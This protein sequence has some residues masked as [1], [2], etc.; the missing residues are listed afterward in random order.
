MSFTIA[1]FISAVLTPLAGLVGRSLGLVDRPKDPTLA[2]HVR[3]V[4]VLGGPAVVAS[5]FV[6]T[7]I[8]GQSVSWWIVVAVALAL[9]VGIADD[10]RPLP[11]LVRLVGLAVAGVL[12]AMRGGE[13][14]TFGLMAAPVLVL[15]TVASA[16]A[17]NL[18]DGQNGLA[19]TLAAAAALGIAG[20]SGGRTDALALTLGGASL[21]F[22]AWNLGGLVFL[23]NGGAYAVGAML[24]AVAAHAVTERGWHGAV[25]AVL[26][27]G[28]FAFE[29]VFTIVRRL[30]T[31][32]ALTSGD[33]LHAYDLVSAS[34]GR[35]ISTATFC[36]AGLVAAGVAIAL[37]HAPLALEASITACLCIAAA[38][39]GRRL[40]SIS[41]RQSRRA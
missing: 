4:P 21:G 38:A 12:L 1:F 14:K 41:I 6:A 8:V 15:A 35:P 27:L 25:A 16:N 28:I 29:L 33:R 31:G 20:L 3:P 19:G 26:C 5:A 2:I 37:E 34:K 9:A 13:L 39:W 40:W 36:A 22:V 30:A 17:V 32:A 23:G 10:V 7:L 24:A 18:V 11:P